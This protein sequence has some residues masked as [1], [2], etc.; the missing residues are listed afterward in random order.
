MLED[1]FHFLVSVAPFKHCV[2]IAWYVTNP[3]TDIVSI[4]INILPINKAG[5]VQYVPECT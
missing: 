3:N 5:K 4:H 2:G 1:N